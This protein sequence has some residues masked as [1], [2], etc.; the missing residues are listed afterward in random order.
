MIN[1]LHLS[2]LRE[3][4]EDIRSALFFSMSES[5]LR[6]PNSLVSAL[7][8]DDIGN[9]WL[10]A[11]RPKQQLKEFEQRFPVRLDFYQ[12]G[13]EFYLNVSGNARII[14]E[15]SELD[16]MLESVHAQKNILKRW[17]LVKVQITDVQYH[18]TAPIAKNNWLTSI[19][20][21]FNKWL[22]PVIPGYTTYNA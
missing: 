22:S 3:K 9:I 21:Q 15:P 11:T 4:I 12:K 7:R 5:V 1:T 17:I 18:G 20:T 10:L 2:F 8:V 16:E 6:L 13:K 19:Y 14:L